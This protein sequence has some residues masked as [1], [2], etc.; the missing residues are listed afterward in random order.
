MTAAPFISWSL[1]FPR[2][3][4]QAQPRF[5]GQN[6]F[7]SPKQCSTWCGVLSITKIFLQHKSKVQN[8]PLCLAGREDTWTVHPLKLYFSILLLFRISPAPKKNKHGPY[9][10]CTYQNTWPHHQCS[11]FG[12]DVTPLSYNKNCKSVKWREKINKSYT[13]YDKM[14]SFQVFHYTHFDLDLNDW[15]II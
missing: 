5:K 4:Y 12:K 2:A 7:K 1:Y 6:T 13:I 10:D 14:S 15:N 8:I 9:I 11:R 3:D